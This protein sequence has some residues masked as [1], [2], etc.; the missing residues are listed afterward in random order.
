MAR[1]A[2]RQQVS[3]KESRSGNDRKPKAERWEELLEAAAKI[4][5][6]KGYDATSIQDIAERVN[7]LKG[8]IYYYIQTKADLRDHLLV[9]VHTN[10][11]ATMRRLA[12][13]EGTA[14][15]KLAAMIRGHVEYMH[16]NRAKTTVYL[17]EVKKLSPAKRQ[18]LLGAENYRDV[19]DE[20]L[21]LGQAEGL[22]LASLDPKQA[23]QAILASLNSFYQWYRPNRESQ[24]R[25]ADYFV[26]T[27]LRGHAS[28]AGLRLLETNP[29]L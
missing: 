5:Y 12:A 8:S 27:I 14:L 7:I 15:D 18:E 4:F 10:G 1:T 16:R 3:P 26:T 9:E 2:A 21:E 28:E 13:T 17:H 24:A 19:F 22:F 25:V 6:E 11:I 20:M 23:A 29:D